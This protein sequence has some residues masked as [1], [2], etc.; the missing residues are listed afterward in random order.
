MNFFSWIIKN[1]V[2]AVGLW[3]IGKW[4]FKKNRHE[5]NPSN[6]FN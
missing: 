4:V 3:T 2:F 1:I 6:Y 5:F